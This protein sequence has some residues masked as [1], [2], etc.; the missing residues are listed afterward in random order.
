MSLVP[1]SNFQIIPNQFELAQPFSITDAGG[2]QAV[3]DPV[4][5]AEGHIVALLLTNPGERVMRPTYGSG[6]LAFIFENNDPLVVQTLVGQV[7]NSL[8]IFEPTISLKQFTL[9]PNPPSSGELQL[10]IQFTVGTSSTLHT[11]LINSNGQVVSL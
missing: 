1:T 9:V 6:L 5:W 4:V 7:Q 11:S 2:V 3:S 10:Q 8:S